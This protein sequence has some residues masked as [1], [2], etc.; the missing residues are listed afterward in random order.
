MKKGTHQDVS[1]SYS[2]NCP[3]CKETTYSDIHNEQ[4]KELEWGDG[5]PNGIIECL[6][7]KK[8]FEVEF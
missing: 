7:C 4:W 1:V 8:E 6:D 2:V 3:H 5:P